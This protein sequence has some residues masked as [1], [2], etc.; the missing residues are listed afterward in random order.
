MINNKKNQPLNILPKNGTNSNDVNNESEEPFFFN[1]GVKHCKD[2]ILK[3]RL[4]TLIHSKG[5]SEPDFYHKVGLSKQ[6][7]YE[8]SW[9]IWDIPIEL[10]VKISQTLGV[11]S[12]VIFQKI[13]E[14]VA[15]EE[16]VA[17]DTDVTPN[18]KKINKEVEK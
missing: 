2:E 13:K 17:I 10:K 1:R 11:D 6:Y 5:M 12:S 7:W 18:I 4:R 9:G 14:E 15:P 16:A 8:L 3:T